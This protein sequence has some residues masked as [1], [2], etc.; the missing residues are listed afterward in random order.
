MRVSDGGP[1]WDP[2]N[3]NTYHIT[4]MAVTPASAAGMN[5]SEIEALFSYLD[6][7]AVAQ[8]GHA[9]TAAAKTLQSIADALVSHA[10][11]LSGGWGGQA[12]QSTVNAFQQLHQTAVQLAQ[13]SAKTGATLTWLGETILPYYKNYKAPS[14]GVVGTIESWFGSNPQDKAAQQ[15][16]ERLNDRLSQANAGL[17]PS[18]TQTLPTISGAEHSNATTGGTGPG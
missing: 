9:H 7:G 13:A 16:M 6:P 8:A 1:S 12:A 4:T 3:G 15:V 14:N 5:A 10:Q 18:V 17:P 2:V 11:T